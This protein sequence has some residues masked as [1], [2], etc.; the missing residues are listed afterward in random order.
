MNLKERLGS[1]FDSFSSRR[2]TLEIGYSFKPKK[3]RDKWETGN[4]KERTLLL[5]S[6]L[7]NG[8]WNTDRFQAQVGRGHEFWVEVHAR[9]QMLYGEYAISRRRVN[10]PLEDLKGFLNECS[11]ERFFD[12]VEQ[13]FRVEA[14]RYLVHE[15]NRLVEGINEVLRFSSVPYQL[16]RMVKRVEQNDTESYGID[17]PGTYTVTITAYPM[18]IGTNEEITH[19]QGV[20]PALAVLEAPHFEAANGELRTALEKYKNN[21]FEECLTRCGS[22][23]ESVLKILCT[24]KG[25]NPKKG[26]TIRPLLGEVVK[27]SEIPSFLE[28]PLISIATIRNRLSSAHGGGSQKRIATRSIAQYTITSTCAAIVLLTEEVET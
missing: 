9:L 3:K 21:E 12:F 22:C 27:K 5:Y 20:W 17:G 18:F 10:S 2:T 13:S 11:T 19:E 23:F 1:I 28:Q 15:E 7:T 8:S 6:Q 16:T 25:W 26:S 14:L 4:F 24:R